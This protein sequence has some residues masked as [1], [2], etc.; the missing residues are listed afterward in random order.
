MG[1]AP[2]VGAWGRGRCS[3]A[4]SVPRGVPVYSRGLQFWSPPPGVPAGPGRGAAPQGAGEGGR[5]SSAT[6]CCGTRPA[7]VTSRR[8]G[9]RGM[10]QTPQSIY[11]L[12]SSFLNTFL[13]CA[14]VHLCPLVFHRQARG[15]P[16]L[17]PGTSLLSPRMPCD[18]H[19]CLPPLPPGPSPPSTA[20]PLAGVKPL[21]LQSQP[22]RAV[23]L[24]CVQGNS[25]L[26]LQVCPGWYTILGL[27]QDGL[28]LSWGLLDV[29]VIKVISP[30][31]AQELSRA[32]VRS[33]QMR[34]SEHSAPKPV[35]ETFPACTTSAPG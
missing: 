1:P 21:C 20:L 14:S 7:S 9:G 26:L 2:S 25:F 27:A 29:V 4:C 33:E 31:A 19:L 22:S 30:A 15:L 10:Y 34:W 5:C 8:D 28:Y 18:S 32:H 16:A 11:Y 24:A 13:Y 23:G 6:S 3:R 12:K 35:H 17:L